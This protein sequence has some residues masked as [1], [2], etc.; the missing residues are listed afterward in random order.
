MPT[1]CDSTE[2]YRSH[3]FVL[4]WDHKKRMLDSNWRVLFINLVCWAKMCPTD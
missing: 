1:Y 3:V 4:S 2:L